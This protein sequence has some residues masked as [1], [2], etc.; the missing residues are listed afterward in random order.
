MQTENTVTVSGTLH[1]IQRDAS[2]AARK[3][4][5]PLSVRQETQG[6]DGSVRKDFLLARIYDPEIQSAL[7]D[8]QE[9]VPIRIRGD[10]RSSLGSGE[11]YINVLNLEALGR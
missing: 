5:L 2:E 9:G 1:L 7:K 3:K 6:A 8:L 4:Y 10:V 11:M